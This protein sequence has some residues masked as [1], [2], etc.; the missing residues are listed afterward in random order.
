MTNYLPTP[1]DSIPQNTPLPF[2]LYIKVAG[3][4]IKF[5][6]TK[7]MLTD[8]RSKSLLEKTDMLFIEEVDWIEFVDYLESICDIEVEN[9]LV[10]AEN[11]QK[12][13]L[14]YGRHLEKMQVLDR[15][16]VEKMRKIAFRMADIQTKWPT[17]QGK[18]LR[19]FKESSIYFSAHSANVAVYGIAIG[20][21][22]GLKDQ[23]IRDLAFACLVHNIGNSLVPEKLLYK[24]G[25]LTEDEWKTVRAHSY[26]GAQLLQYLDAPSEAV[27]TARQHHEHIDGKGY[28]L[29][30]SGSDIHLYAKICS[31]ADVYDALITPK[32]YGRPPLEP[33][34]ALLEMR[35]MTGK[36]DPKMLNMMGNA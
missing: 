30:L 35:S 4:I 16:T 9:P 6:N 22:L 11:V 23:E 33:S 1:I 24:N 29:C 13:L 15:T 34:D 14:A 25:K 21:K 2:P 8:E 27:L 3:K 20:K 32:P 26:Q 36:F 17:V 7:D 19:R 31:I 12:L 5:R 28:P 18:L 10:A